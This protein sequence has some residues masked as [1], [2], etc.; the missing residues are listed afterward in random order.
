MFIYIC[1]HTQ[2][3]IY[4]Y[5][6]TNVMSHIRTSGAI[7]W[8]RFVYVTWRTHL[9]DIT[10]IC[11]MTHSYFDMYRVNKLLC[12]KWL[13]ILEP[14]VSTCDMIYPYVWSEFITIATVLIMAPPWWHD[15]LICVAWLMIRMCDMSHAY[16]WHDSFLIVAPEA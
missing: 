3:F 8:L 1:V 9:C 4:T 10:H 16:V 5:V 7:L 6:C 14:E 15:S 12:V 13:Q 2:I 11:D